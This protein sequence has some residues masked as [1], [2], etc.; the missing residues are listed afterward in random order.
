MTTLKTAVVMCPLKLVAL[1]RGSEAPLG[2]LKP[3]LGT[4]KRSTINQTKE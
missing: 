3:F 1:K 2:S 4:L